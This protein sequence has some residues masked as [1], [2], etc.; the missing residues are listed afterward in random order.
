MT[1][2]ASEWIRSYER[3]RLCENTCSSVAAER[4][5]TLAPRFSAGFTYNEPCVAAATLET[6]AYELRIH[7][8][9]HCRDALFTESQTQR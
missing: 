5:L 3:D 2:N 1:I 8:K 7:F 4:R 6:V 9:R